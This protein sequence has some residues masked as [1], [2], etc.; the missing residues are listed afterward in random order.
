SARRSSSTSWGRAGDRVGLVSSVPAE[1]AGIGSSSTRLR[2]SPGFDP[3]KAQVGPDEYFVL[4]RIDGAQTVREVLLSTGLPVER[5]IAI[6]LKLRSIGALL[7]PGETAAPMPAAAPDA[8]PPARA[9]AITPA[10]PLTPP[11][12][13]PAV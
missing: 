3:L 13:I 6:V 11:H 4:S 2:V 12:G 5:G 1:I 10:A 8:T 9:P 7:L